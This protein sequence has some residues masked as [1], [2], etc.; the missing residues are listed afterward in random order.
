MSRPPPRQPSRARGSPRTAPCAGQRWGDGDPKEGHRISWS[1]LRRV[2]EG[3]SG[4][5][6]PPLLRLDIAPR[7][8]EET[9]KE[10]GG[11]EGL[12]G[13]AAV[14]VRAPAKGT[15]RRRGRV[16]GQVGGNEIV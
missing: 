11:E 14:K 5:K 7:S 6:E 9:G 12:Q 3:T 2:G 16:G 4:E 13:P 1:S 10:E 8:R 15:M